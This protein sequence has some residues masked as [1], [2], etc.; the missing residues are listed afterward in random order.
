MWDYKGTGVKYLKVLEVLIILAFIGL[1]STAEASVF[2][3]GAYPGNSFVDPA[4]SIDVERFSIGSESY[5]APFTSFTGEYA[6]IG[7]Y[8]DVQDSGTNSGR[9]KIADDAVIAHG[10]DLSGDVEVGSKAFIGFNSVIKD[11]KIGDGAYIGIGSKVIGIDIPAKK[12]VPPAS[13][14]DGAEDIGKLTPVT[15]EQVE[16]VNEVIEVNRAL[17]VGYSQLFEKSGLNAFDRVGPNGD[18]D[19]IIDGKDILARSGS[20]EPV[21]GKGSIIE[22][23]RIIGDVFIGENS[24]IDDGTSIRGDEGIPIKIGKNA[25]ISKNNT[26]HSLNNKE[27]TIGDNFKLGSDSVIHG[28]LVI[29]DNVSVG[30]RAVVFRST[31][32]SN[33]IIGDNAIVVDVNVPDGIVIPPGYVATKQMYI[34]KLNPGPVSKPASLLE[35]IGAAFIPI[36]LGLAGSY[37][38]RDRKH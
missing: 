25:Q 1:V 24:K 10:A 5:I 17:A 4:A 15:E 16:F 8:S 6:I 3:T 7:S 12:S 31:I 37:I 29:G 26:F 36:A 11:S 14:I 19:I 22:S 21:I 20:H 28:Y 9:I 38:L 33:V 32:G 34:R 27:I 2:K 35:L 30:N 23:S 13:V 18:G